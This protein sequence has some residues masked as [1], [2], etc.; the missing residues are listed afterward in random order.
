MASVTGEMLMD[1]KKVK[2]ILARE[3]E[4]EVE[5]HDQK[6]RDEL[7]RQLDA[8]RAEDA[9]SIKTQM[10]NAL[11]IE[12]DGLYRK[13]EKFSRECDVG[14]I[15]L[16]SLLSVLI[17]VNIGVIVASIVS[18][19]KAPETNNLVQNS[20]AGWETTMMTMQNATRH[21]MFAMMTSLIAKVDRVQ[22]ITTNHASEF[23]YFSLLL[24][25]I[26]GAI[27]LFAVLEINAPRGFRH[28]IID[29]VRVVANDYRLIDT[30]LKAIRDNLDKMSSEK[31]TSSCQ[32]CLGQAAADAQKREEERKESKK[33]LIEQSNMLVKT[34]AI[35]EYSEVVRT[36]WRY[37]VTPNL[38]LDNLETSDLPMIQ[39]V[40]IILKQQLKKEMLALSQ[41]KEDDST[42][43]TRVPA[44]PIA[45]ASAIVTPPA[46]GT[47]TTSQ[48]SIPDGY[49]LSV[50]GQVCMAQYP[51]PWFPISQP[52]AK[53][54]TTY[55][56]NS[57]GATVTAI[58]KP[59]SS[60][61]CKSPVVG[62]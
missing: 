14:T 45:N 23:W 2:D 62:N 53:S 41:K 30:G 19:A 42:N 48:K 49:E 44:Q 17:L 43:K 33:K 61:T 52:D 26:I 10:R 55:V 1:E 27:V 8:R 3:H 58:T 51:A 32:K 31:D 36:L 9:E 20:M 37:G 5:A 28:A 6:V 12:H 50:D 46:E 22:T 16:I 47:S 56:T 13:I 29:E 18:R 60:I 38:L 54:T 11:K 39:H 21:E 59:S 34:S 25:I 7:L 15:I 35:A 57:K 24:W 40:V 4:R